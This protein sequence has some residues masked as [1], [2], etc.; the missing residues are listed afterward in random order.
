MRI[1]TPY[2]FHGESEGAAVYGEKGYLI[3][4]NTRWRAYGP[5]SKLIKEGT[6]DSDATPHVQNFIDCIKSRERPACDLETV[7]HPA[8]ILCHAG[9]ISARLGRRVV[10]DPE[11]EMFE[12]D[13]EANALRGRPE[14]RKPWELPEV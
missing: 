12:N 11:T 10:L 2:N 9:N 1:W 4:G 3:I 14:W 13:D 6:G 8:S 5:G 7:G